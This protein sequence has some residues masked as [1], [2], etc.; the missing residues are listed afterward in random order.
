VAYLALITLVPLGLTARFVT[1]P[2]DSAAQFA[3]YLNANVDPA[4]VIETWDPELGVLTDHL[5]KYPPQQLLDGTVRAEWLGG[6]PPTYDWWSDSP[7][8][9]A[10]GPFSAYARVYAV[11]ALDT[12]YREVYRVGQYGLY[13]RR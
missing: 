3:A 12:S 7:D 1:T 5:Y 11:E 4:A 6:T 8:Y 10:V 9:V 2:D 13:Q